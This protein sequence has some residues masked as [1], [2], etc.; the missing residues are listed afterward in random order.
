M[1]SSPEPPTDEESSNTSSYITQC[2]TLHNKLLSLSHPTSPTIPLPAIST[3]PTLPTPDSFLPESLST[4]LYSPTSLLARLLPLLNITGTPNQAQTQTQCFNNKPLTPIFHQPHPAMFYLPLFQYDLE[5]ADS[6]FVCLYP[7]RIASESPHDGG[8][9]VDVYNLRAAWHAGPGHGKML[10]LDGWVPLHEVLLREIQR[11]ESGKYFLDGELEDGVGIKKWVEDDLED[12]VWGW[13]RLVRV[14]RRQQKG[15]NDGDGDDDDDDEDEDE[16][17]VE[18]QNPISIEVLDSLRIGGFAKA[19]LARAKRPKGIKFV[20]PGI[21]IFDDNAIREAYAGEPEDSLRIKH[22]SGDPDDAKEITSLIFPGPATAKIT[23]KQHYMTLN[24]RVGL[25]VEGWGRDAD[26]VRLVTSGGDKGT[27][28][29]KKQCPWGP[30]RLARLAE[31]LAQR[32]WLIE[33]GKW[34]VGDEGVIDEPEWFDDGAHADLAGLG[35]KEF[36]DDAQPEE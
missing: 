27:C 8:L 9:F 33:N 17:D 29:F 20:A 2:A 19:F 26:V 30:D 6:P 15:K 10:P 4:H 3:L 25:Y 28:Q 18:W 36:N 34:T 24:G 5:D 31:V 11:W 21:T 1:A 12:A 35:W 13:E 14:I 32:T 16:N 22:A 7:Q 23:D